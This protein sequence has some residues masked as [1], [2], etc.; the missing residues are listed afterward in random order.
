MKRFNLDRLGRFN[1]ERGDVLAILFDDL[2]DLYILTV[3]F[4]AIWKCFLTS[5]LDNIPKC[6]LDS[7]LSDSTYSIFGTPPTT[8]KR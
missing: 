4:M 6:F 5:L 3:I 2:L 1:H 7:T 8:L